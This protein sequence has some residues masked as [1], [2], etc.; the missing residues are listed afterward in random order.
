MTL[1]LPLCRQRHVG[2][3]SGRGKCRPRP[4]ARPPRPRRARPPA[5]R[6]AAQLFELARQP[7]ADLARAALDLAPVAGLDLQPF[8]EPSFEAAQGCRIRRAR[9]PVHELVEQRQRVVESHLGDIEVGGAHRPRCPNKGRMRRRYTRARASD[10]PGSCTR[11]Q[12][13]PPP[14]GHRA[15]P[16]RSLGDDDPGSVRADLGAVRRVPPRA[17]WRVRTEHG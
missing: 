1:V 9:A 2:S 6:L 7:L 4:R 3:A 12:A 14:N 17:A 8:G 5:V 11:P 13:T 15:T 16:H 10:R